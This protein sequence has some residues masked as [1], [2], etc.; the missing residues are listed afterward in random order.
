MIIDDQKNNSKNFPREDKTVGEF[1]EKQMADQEFL[2]TVQKALETAINENDE[3]NN[4][5]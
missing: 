4:L 3:V 5:I 2:K 1:N